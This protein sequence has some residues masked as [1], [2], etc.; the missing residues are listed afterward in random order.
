LERKGVFGVVQ[1]LDFDLDF[2][3]AGGGEIDLRGG[4]GSS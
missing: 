4:G 1:N 2:D 3:H